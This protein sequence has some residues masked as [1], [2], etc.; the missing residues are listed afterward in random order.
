[1]KERKKNKKKVMNK[2]VVMGGVYLKNKEKRRG[3]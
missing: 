1:L 2:R 3:E